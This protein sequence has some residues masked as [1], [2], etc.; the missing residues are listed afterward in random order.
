MEHV[1]W[2]WSGTYYKFSEKDLACQ[3][4]QAFQRLSPNGTAQDVE[5]FK[6]ELRRAPVAYLQRD[7]K[8]VWFRNGVWDYRTRTLTAYE[9]PSFE[10]K[11]PDQITLG[12]LP[13]FHPYGA[14]A[15][16]HPDAAGYVAEPIIQND[17]DGTDWH[18][19]QM[20]EDPFD[21]TTAEGRASS[22]IIWQTMQFTIRHLNGLPGHPACHRGTEAGFRPVP[23]HPDRVCHRGR[24]DERGIWHDICRQV[25]GC[26]NART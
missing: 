12:K 7:D 6:R 10:A 21:M 15:V 3:I 13:V 2:K 25:R 8:L 24:R 17:K 5:T 1:T 18:P 26:Q 11:Y 19:G 22:L 20:L 16:L 4:M 23:K 14:G 9:D